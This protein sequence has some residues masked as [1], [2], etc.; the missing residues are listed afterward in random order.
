[1]RGR[2]TIDKSSMNLSYFLYSVRIINNNG[3]KITRS[4]FIEE[5]S[6][7]A[8]LP[9]QLENGQE[10][11]TPF[12][13]SKLPRYFGFIDVDN[14]GAEQQLVLTK[15]GKA[16][17]S[18]ISEQKAND[19]DNRYTIKKANKISFSDLIFESVVFGT[20]GKNNCGAETSNTDVEPPK[21]LFRLLF[22]IN[23]ATAEEFCYLIF[24]LNNGAFSTYEEGKLKILNNRKN[25]NNDYSMILQKWKVEN[26]A[27]DCKIINFFTDGSIDLIASRKDE[28]SKKTFYHITEWALKR[29][30]G[31]LQSITP[32]YQPLRL[33]VSITGKENN[34]DDALGETIFGGVS[35]DSFIYKLTAEKTNNRMLIYNAVL[36]AFKMP[37]KNIYLLIQAST[38]EQ[39]AQRVE[40]FDALFETILD[41]N[42]P[43]NGFSKNQ[44]PD[45]SGYQFL[46]THFT[47]KNAISSLSE[48]CIRFPSNLHVIGVINMPKTN[49]DYKFTRCIIDAKTADDLIPTNKLDEVQ[50]VKGGEN[51]ILYGVPGAGKSYTI[52]KDYCNDESKIE[53]I[54]FHPDYS[55]SDFVGQILP[56]IDERNGKVSYPFSPGPF[57]NILRRAYED[58]SNMYYLVIEE[59]NRGN[60]PAIFGDLFQLLDRDEDGTSIYGI[61]NPDVALSVYSDK[62]HK[63]RIPS[64]L[65]LLCTMNT[66]DQNVFTLD[67]AFQRR[68]NMRLIEN[69]FRKDT[70]E[71]KNFAEMY[72]LDSGVSWEDF[73]NL[74]NEYILEQNITMTSAEDKRLGTHFVQR[75]DLEYYSIVDSESASAE[76]KN[77]A[78]LHNRKFPEKVI[79]YLWDDAFKF[80]RSDIFNTEKFKSLE[81]IIKEFASKKGIERFDIFVEDIKNALDAINK[82]TV[83]KNSQVKTSPSG[84]GK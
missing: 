63:V 53:R 80:Q 39:F 50:R 4:K 48:N 35:D 38:E 74:M 24:G 68:W 52:Q 40:G 28:K 83:L 37:S 26:Y 15:R 41:L 58:P 49:I 72:I 54:V 57:T 13:K 5:M 8:N 12:N 43:Y 65:S 78:R 22:D 10:N 19:P 7:F 76:E 33:F 34:M 46:V 17:L 42:A 30:K 11:R 36:N 25:G 59:V 2:L 14:S 69:T 6:A 23:E 29:Y 67:T 82:E 62:T 47:T 75:S 20:F 32:I 77:R 55:Y 66:S 27:H 16:L 1:M 3:G 84:E 70:K 56:R 21:V 64:N 60:A 51:T 79:K 61:T 81:A 71:E 31:Q 45:P 73:C 9:L 18:C 44:I